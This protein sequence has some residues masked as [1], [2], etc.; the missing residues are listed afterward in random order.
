MVAVPT[1]GWPEL[2]L[3]LAVLLLLFGARK[4]PD[5]ARSIGKST[6]EFK[7]GMREA[8]QE[9]LTGSDEAAEAEEPRTTS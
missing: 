5:I 4:L 9:D 7:K 1:L 3:V 2:L 6:S 8:K